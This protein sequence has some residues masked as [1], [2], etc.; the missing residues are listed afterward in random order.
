MC[1]ILSFFHHFSYIFARVFKKPAFLIDFPLAQ[2][3]IFN[4]LGNLRYLDTQIHPK[5]RQKSPHFC[6][7]FQF[8][9]LF[10][11]QNHPTSIIALLIFQADIS[12]FVPPAF[13]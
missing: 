10:S 6:S 12:V 1:Q 5:I 9:F 13:E 4:N 11:W 7:I 8:F 2:F 3:N